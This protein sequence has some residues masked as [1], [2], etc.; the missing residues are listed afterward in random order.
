MGNVGAI[1]PALMAATTGSADQRST[2]S[3]P[4]PVA[5]DRQ[6]NGYTWRYYFHEFPSSNFQF[7]PL[8]QAEWYFVW[9]ALDYSRRAALT[10]RYECKLAENGDY[11]LLAP[12]CRAD[13]PTEQQWRHCREVGQRYFDLAI[14]RKPSMPADHNLERANRRYVAFE[15]AIDPALSRGDDNAKERGVGT[16]SR[17]TDHHFLRIIS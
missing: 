9:S 5:V 3:M 1:L 17:E 6:E 7:R 10:V 4:S 8:S 11:A 12:A 14:K 2:A 16:H 13:C 15:I